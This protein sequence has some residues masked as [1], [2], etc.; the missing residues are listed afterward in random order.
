MF[1]VHFLYLN[2][3]E[4]KKKRNLLT[5]SQK[6]VITIHHSVIFSRKLTVEHAGLLGGLVYS[7]VMVAHDSL[8]T[9]LINK[10]TVWGSLPCL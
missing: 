4:K 5:M 6:C 8:C 10:L 7:P 9:D 2:A 1:G 3:G